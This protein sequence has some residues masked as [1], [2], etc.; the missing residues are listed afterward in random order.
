MTKADEGGS[1]REHTLEITQL[2]TSL[3]AASMYLSTGPSLVSSSTFPPSIPPPIPIPNP[4]P[5]PIPNPIPNPKQTTINQFT[6]RREITEP[7]H[8]NRKLC[9]ANKIPSSPLQSAFVQAHLIV[10]PNK[11]S[12]HDFMMFSLLNK[13]PIFDTCPEGNYTPSAVASW[14]DLRTDLPSYDIIR[15]GATSPQSP[16]LDVKSLW[17]SSSISF[18]LLSNSIFDKLL[19]DANLTSRSLE[20]NSSPPKFIAKKLKMRTSG[21]IIGGRVVVEMRPFKGAEVGKVLAVLA[22]LPD[23]IGV[24]IWCGVDGG[25]IGVDLGKP[26]NVRDGSVAVLKD[27]ICIFHVCAYSTSV[28]HLKLAGGAG[29]ID[30]I[31]TSGEGSLLMTD[32][33]LS[34]L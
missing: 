9:R 12:S 34:E 20:L 15:G 25:G 24:P 21:G 29:G 5:P 7:A 28:E 16:F 6:F 30:Q 8:A 33:R 23:K 3:Q 14:A 31:I 11:A 26:L 17:P 4:I 2:Q 13:L 27:E 19:I 32:V 10:L 22:G 18:L 1:N